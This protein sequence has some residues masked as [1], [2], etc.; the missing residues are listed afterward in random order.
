[1]ASV[2]V[3]VPEGVGRGTW[4]RLLVDSMTDRRRWSAVILCPDCGKPLVL[5]NH[6][7]S[8]NGQVSPSVGHPSEFPACGWHQHPRLVGWSLPPLP[9][10]PNKE[11]CERCG[12]TTYQVSGWGTWSGGSGIICDKCFAERKAGTP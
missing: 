9:P 10:L 5:I 7:I 1:M 3:D 2:L 12:T 4:Q 6:T 8:A 11:T